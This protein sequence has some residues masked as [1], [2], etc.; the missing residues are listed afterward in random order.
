M[1]RS[2]G[3]PC[4]RLLSRATLSAPRISRP[5]HI[6][7][8]ASY[9]TKSGIEAYTAWNED[10]GSVASSPAPL[11]VE[12]VGEKLQESRHLSNA[13]IL[14]MVQSRMEWYGDQILAHRTG[15]SSTSGGYLHIHLQAFVDWADSHHDQERALA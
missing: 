11:T 15:S 2:F 10:T 4:S 1:F 3:L 8:A 12:E 14:D 7:P 9:A 6:V 5:M 13:R